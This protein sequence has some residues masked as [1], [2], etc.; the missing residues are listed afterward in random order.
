[1]GG[2]AVIPLISKKLALDIEKCRLTQ[3]RRQL[4]PYLCRTSWKFDRERA[5]SEALPRASASPLQ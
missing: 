4:P 5:T 1:M 2:K 3:N